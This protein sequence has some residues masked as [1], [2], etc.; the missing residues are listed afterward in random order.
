MLSVT[1]AFTRGLHMALPLEL[2][3]SAVIDQRIQTGQTGA[4]GEKDCQQQEGARGTAGAHHSKI[5]RR[6]RVGRSGGQS[7]DGTGGQA[8]SRTADQKNL[9]S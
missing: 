3:T 1:D 2:G 6:S 8:D 7:V 4:G 5:V 9:S